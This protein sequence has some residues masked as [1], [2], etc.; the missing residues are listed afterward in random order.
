MKKSKPSLENF[1]EKEIKTTSANKLKGGH[2]TTLI[3]ELI[4]AG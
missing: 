4:V 2:N 1:S 3:T